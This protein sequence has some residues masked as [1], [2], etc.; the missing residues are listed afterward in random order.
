MQKSSAKLCAALTIFRVD[1]HIILDTILPFHPLSKVAQ[2]AFLDLFSP[3]SISKGDYFAQESQYTSRLGFVVSGILRAYY[4]DQ[5]GKEYN[6]TFFP[7]RTFVTSLA[8]VLL[9]QPGYLNFDALTDVQL[10]VADYYEMTALFEPHR[11][12]ETLVRKFIEYEW[13]IKKELRELR[14][15]LN[16]AEERYLFFRQEYPGLEDRI[17]QYHIA[18]HLGITPIQLS[19]IRARMAGK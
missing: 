1:K 10:W 13:V 17:P 14:L 5:N 12:I 19:R 2:Q 3:L 4:A 16:N 15:V 7:E 9:R 8:A 18:S 6:K 11:E